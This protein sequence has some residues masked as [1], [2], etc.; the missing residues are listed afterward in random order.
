MNELKFNIWKEIAGR[1]MS[2]EGIDEA[3]DA[4]YLM[5]IELLND[6]NTHLFSEY[7][8]ADF[9]KHDIEE[10]LKTK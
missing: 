7:Y 6:Y 5:I 1:Q 2:K 8:Y 3:T 4:I 9:T 10:F